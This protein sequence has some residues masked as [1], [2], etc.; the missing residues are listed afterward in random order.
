M[1]TS[2]VHESKMPFVFYRADDGKKFNSVPL[3][4]ELDDRKNANLSLAELFPTWKLNFGSPVGPF[5]FIDSI[6]SIDSFD[7][8]DSIGPV[9]IVGLVGAIDSIGASIWAV[10]PVGSRLLGSGLRFAG[11]FFCH[12]LAG[13]GWG[14]AAT[15]SLAVAKAFATESSVFSHCN[16]S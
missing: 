11:L 16:A 13:R 2:R 15:A 9:G 4:A 8:I 14:A 7:S 1:W 6:D 3:L 10:G 5:D 12:L